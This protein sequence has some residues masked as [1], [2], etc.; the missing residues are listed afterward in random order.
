M[1]FDHTRDNPPHTHGGTDVPDCQTCRPV[2]VPYCSGLDSRG[3]VWCPDHYP[4][5]Y[6]KKN[7]KHRKDRL[8]GEP[9][10]LYRES[11]DHRYAGIVA[12][13]TLALHPDPD[14]LLTDVEQHALESIVSRC[15]SGWEDI[16]SKGWDALREFLRDWSE[17]RWTE[18]Y[19]A[20]DKD[21]GGQ[22]TY[23]PYKERD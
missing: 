5:E 20:R 11:R 17:K 21:N 19:V 7:A 18:G 15:N 9:L 23:N 22:L 1:R 3:Q 12:E 14:H 2:R 13:T 10:R 8:Y 6:A 16:V 4:V